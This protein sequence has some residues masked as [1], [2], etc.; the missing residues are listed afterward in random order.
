MLTIGTGVVD[1]VYIGSTHN[2]DIY[3]GSLKT[4]PGTEFYIS[5]Q[6]FDMYEDDS[7]FHYF[8]NEMFSA[9]TIEDLVVR[10]ITTANTGVA[11]LV[12]PQS[13]WI[14]QNNG[15]DMCDDDTISV[16]LEVRLY[17]EIWAG[18]NLIAS[19]D[20]FEYAGQ[21]RTGYYENPVSNPKI[22]IDFSSGLGRGNITFKLKEER[23]I[24]LDIPHVPA[25]AYEYGS[26][27]AP[28]VT[29]KMYQ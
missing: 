29:I 25:G 26:I 22:F 8:G 4:F 24:Y 10:Y 5:S 16:E 23:R 11:V 17:I 12:F 6:M 1:D 21:P 14:V 9:H 19:E 3:A 2:P 18:S 28:N 13:Q 27:A 20:L 15:P 7:N